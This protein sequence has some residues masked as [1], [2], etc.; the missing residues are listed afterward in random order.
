M[1][2]TC[3]ADLHGN[4]PETI[5]GDL[6][7]IAGDITARDTHGE[8]DN[9]RQWLRCQDYTMKIVIGGNHDNGF[10]VTECLDM[11]RVYCDGATYLCDEGI[12]FQGVKIWGTPWSP[13]FH[14]VNPR[15]KAFMDKENKIKKKFDMIPEG[16]DILISHCPPFGILDSVSDWHTG[17]VKC[18][19]SASLLERIG[20]VKPKLCVFGHIHEHGGKQMLY[21]HIGPNTLCINASYVD[22]RYRVSNEPIN[23][24]MEF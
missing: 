18:V 21:K 10:V 4:V 14:G 15:C 3:T 23:I 11:T 13:W 20:I 6:L 7:I 12:E 2:I 1:K 8:Y 22:E 19:G 16:T 17:E 5:G 9:F 24:E